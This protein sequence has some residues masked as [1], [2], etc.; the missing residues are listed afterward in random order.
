MSKNPH[1]ILSALIPFRPAEG[2]SLSFTAST[3]EY[4]E[5][6]STLDIMPH[7]LPRYIH[8][9]QNMFVGLA[10][11]VSLTIAKVADFS[12]HTP[13]NAPGCI[14]G[15]D[16]CLHHYGPETPDDVVERFISNFSLIE[17]RNLQT[18]ELIIAQFR[19][20][21]K[22]LR[23]TAFNKLFSE[24]VS[25]TKL[26][27][28]PSTLI[29]N[30]IKNKSDKSWF[31]ALKKIMLEAYSRSHASTGQLSDWLRARYQS[32]GKRRGRYGIIPF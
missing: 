11:Y 12:L 23:N 10:L 15:F 27:T 8:D 28:V 19:N 22:P 32:K 2:C 20:P 18:I 7:I 21:L 14:R 17:F 13:V 1:E 4:D 24:L 26:H 5:L 9:Y 25:V 16:F 6:A 3:K 31:P 30:T 29:L